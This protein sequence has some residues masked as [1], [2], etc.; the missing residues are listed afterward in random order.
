MYTYVNKCEG[1]KIEQRKMKVKKKKGRN[2]G[3]RHSR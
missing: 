1:D 3:E 2:C